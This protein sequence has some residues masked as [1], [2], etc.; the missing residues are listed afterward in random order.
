[1]YVYTTIAIIERPNHARTYQMHNQKK[2]RSGEFNENV[3]KS[4][5]KELL[6]VLSTGVKRIESLNIKVDSF[7]LAL[8]RLFL[9]ISV[10]LNSCK[11]NFG[12]IRVVL[13]IGNKGKPCA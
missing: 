10:F 5:T 11:G 1:M 8:D 12:G 2:S 13:H 6:H 7:S 3:L 4:G 9:F